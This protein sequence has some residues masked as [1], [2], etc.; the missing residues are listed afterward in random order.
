VSR[1]ID[2]ELPG[3]VIVRA[4]DRA[5]NITI[6]NKK[7]NDPIE[8]IKKLNKYSG[9]YMMQKMTYTIKTTSATAVGLNKNPLRNPVLSARVFVKNIVQR[10]PIFPFDL[11][12]SSMMHAK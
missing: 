3:K 11:E 12:V 8:V 2:L 9:K 4:N 10:Y 6:S 5:I 1:I 7:K